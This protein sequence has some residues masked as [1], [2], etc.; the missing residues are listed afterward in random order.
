MSY[1]S[2]YLFRKIIFLCIIGAVGLYLFEPLEK[3][4][5][6]NV[7]MN[8]GILLT[9]S[10]GIIFTIYQL[11]L[12][13]KEQKWLHAFS[14]G[15]EKFPGIPK[16]VILKPLA[17]F[18]SQPTPQFNAFNIQ[19]LLTSIESRLDE[20]RDFNRYLIGLL[21][22]L[23]LLGT[24][25]GLSLTISAI[26]G[27]ISGIDVGANSIKD[28]FQTLKHGLKSPLAGMGTAFSSSMFGLGGSLILGFLDL[29]IGKASRAF[30]NRLEEK[31]ILLSQEK[32]VPQN[33]NAGGPAYLQGM[34]EYI[35][36]HIAQLSQVIRQGEENRN[37]LSKTTQQLCLE[38][39]KLTNAFSEQHKTWYDSLKLSEATQQHL[40]NFFPLQ[41]KMLGQLK[42][43]ESTELL[44]KVEVLLQQ[45]LTHSIEGRNQGVEELRQEIRLVTKTLSAI[46]NGQE[47]AA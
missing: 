44:R 30:Y 31:F 47:I 33:L 1:L 15:E 8:S 16:P 9:L 5:A 28:A 27:V 40:K 32:A 46:A 36:E 18:T 41:E 4:F 12:L 42:N 29:N 43:Q 19:S 38:L 7:W 22:F 35:A 11:A 10:L 37:A 45:L 39:G 34:L 23:G 13:N 25:W 2:F 14:K 17:T 24:F 6:N 21:V 26:A 20:L 3:V